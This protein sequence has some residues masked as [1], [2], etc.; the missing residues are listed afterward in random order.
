VRDIESN[1][2]L[3]G[4]QFIDDQG[5]ILGTSD[6]AGQVVLLSDV[7]PSGPL[8]AT[9]AGYA[10]QDWNASGYWSHHE[11]SI[12]LRKQPSAAVGEEHER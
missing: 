5:H 4:V 7:W 2:P 6:R 12:W 9:L 3:S 11:A 1:E 10:S 8:Q